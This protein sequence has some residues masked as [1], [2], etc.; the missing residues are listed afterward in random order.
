MIDCF[1]RW[2]P[3]VAVAFYVGLTLGDAWKPAPW[4]AVGF[5]SRCSLLVR[6]A[7]GRPAIWVCTGGGSEAELMRRLET[8]TALEL[9]EDDQ[10][11]APAKEPSR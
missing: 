9:A 5:F 1:N 4:P 2:L 8:P 6:T 7:A 10:C 3:W 11:V